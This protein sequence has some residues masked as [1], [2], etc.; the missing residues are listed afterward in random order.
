[1]SG[2]H[3]SILIVGAGPVG[4][5]L[6]IGLARRGI[7]SDIIDM[8]SAPSRFCRAIG[9]TPRT[10]EVFEAMGVARDILNAGL[11][12]NGRRTIVHRG[13]EAIVHD[14]PVEFPELPYSQYGVPQDRTEAVLEA[15]LEQRGIRVTRSTELVRL[16]TGPDGQTVEL[17]REGA[18]ETRRYDYVVGCDGAHSAVRKALGIAFDGSAFPYDFMLGDVS[19]D[20]ELP[21]GTSLQAIRPAVDAP[22]DFFVAIPL[23]EQNRYRVSM[24]ASSQP[25]GARDGEVAHG[26][27]SERPGASLPQLQEV[28]DRLVPG[29]PKLSDLRWSSIFRISMRLAARYR[30]GN[31]FLAGDACH[32]HP[33]TG[34]QGM[35][36]GIQ[37]ADNLA[38]KLALVARGEAGP[39]LL[40]SYEEERRPVA[41]RVIADTVERSISMGKPSAPPDRL[42]DTQIRVSYAGGPLASG[43]AQGGL[44][45]GDRMPDIPGLRQRGVGFP[46]RL[47][48]LT[49]G[50]WFTLLAFAGGRDGPDLQSIFARLSADFPGKVACIAV[51]RQGSDEEALPEITVVRAEAEALQAALGGS[52]PSLVLLRPDGYI[53]FVGEMAF[54][55]IRDCLATTLG[56]RAC[57]ETH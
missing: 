52:P 7:R 53:G 39:A 37:D 30:I 28:A 55:P 17:E 31:V 1:M 11:Q 45:P 16:K 27:Q 10:L 19:I 44:A 56:L 36:T 5:S 21:R 23:P 57:S 12:L 41:E 15:A 38:W 40:D 32:I 14:Q 26:I 25:S 2:S 47:F 46:L 24:M 22:P 6:A 48:D 33:P 13:A 4:L 51:F 50:P 54:D 42:Q 29:Q 3:S 20:W 8:A 43:I 18:T 35:N 9:I 49:R 34:G